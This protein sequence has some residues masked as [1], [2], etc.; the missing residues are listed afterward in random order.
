M[1]SRVAALLCCANGAYSPS[2]TA[3]YACVPAS[4]GAAFPALGAAPFK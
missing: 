2:A 3:Q 4:C 1:A